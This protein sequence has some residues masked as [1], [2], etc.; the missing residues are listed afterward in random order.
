MDESA[1]CVGCVGSEH[2]IVPSD[3]KEHYTASLENRKSVTIAET[4]KA[5]GKDDI[6]IYHRSGEEDYR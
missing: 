1:A 3:I 4:I 5:D 2:I 6:P